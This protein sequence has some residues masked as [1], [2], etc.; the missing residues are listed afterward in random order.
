VEAGQRVMSPRFLSDLSY[1]RPV[2]DRILSLVLWIPVSFVCFLH[3]GLHWMAGVLWVDL[4]L[5]ER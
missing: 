2:G 3:C 5:C 1:S 4:L